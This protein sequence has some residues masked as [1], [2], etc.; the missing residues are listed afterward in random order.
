MLMKRSVF[1]TTSAAIEHCSPP[2][3]FRRMC[4]SAYHLQ[5]RS[6]VGSK[7]WVLFINFLTIVLLL[8]AVSCVHNT[9]KSRT[10]HKVSLN[11]QSATGAGGKAVAGYNVYRGTASGGPYAKLAGVVKETKYQDE[12]V[13]SGTTYYYVVTSVDEAGHESEHSAE[14][15]ARVP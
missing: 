6:G 1:A 8:V 11:W 5:M 3:D 7:I 9:E 4:H 12:L 10:P 13:N 15:Q 14:I 2:C